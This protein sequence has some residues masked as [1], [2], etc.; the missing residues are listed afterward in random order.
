VNQPRR[1]ESPLKRVGPKAGGRGAGSVSVE[2]LGTGGGT[3]P[4]GGCWETHL[5]NQIIKKNKNGNKDISAKKEISRGQGDRNGGP[6]KL[7]EDHRGQIIPLR[8][9]GTE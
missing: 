5:R 4:L 9:G 8:M 7:T 6:G 3:S 1:R 2:K